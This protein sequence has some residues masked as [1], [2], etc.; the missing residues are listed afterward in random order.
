MPDPIRRDSRLPDNGSRGEAA[1]EE[2]TR[3]AIER[4]GAERSFSAD[5]PTY[6]MYPA[7]PGSGSERAV[8][9]RLPLDP[10]IGAVKNESN[11]SPQLNAMAESIGSTL[12][13]AQRQ[14]QVVAG[15]NVERVQKTVRTT[16]EQ[17]QEKLG[18]AVEDWK[19]RAR[20]SVQSASV[21]AQEAM[22]QLKRT[23]NERVEA[24]RVSLSKSAVE[25]R[26]QL[27]VAQRKAQWLADEKPVQV[28]VGAFAVGLAVGMLLK[29]G[30]N[31]NA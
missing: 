19:S 25:M 5:V 22:D 26:K 13:R 8:R 17:T 2:A 21:Q 7:E 18:D 15:K 11:H 14:L 16:V 3:S 30:R 10:A 24:A 4:G 12:G 1:H 23:A 28:V 29:L 31:D 20:E 6:D 27:A 9:E